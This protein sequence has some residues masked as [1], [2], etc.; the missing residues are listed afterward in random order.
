MK[1]P[2]QTHVCLPGEPANSQTSM[3]SAMKS[4]IPDTKTLMT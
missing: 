4:E 1:F 3:G 2:E